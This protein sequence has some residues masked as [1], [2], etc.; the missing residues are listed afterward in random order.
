MIEYAKIRSRQ[1]RDFPTD[2]I[3][4]Q[5]RGRPGEEGRELIHKWLAGLLAWLG[6]GPAITALAYEYGI[7]ITAGLGCSFAT[8]SVFTALRSIG[9][10]NLAMFL[11]LSGAAF[12]LVL[13]PFLIFGWGPFPK[14]GL[15]G[16][17]WAT[18]TSQAL[19]ILAGLGLLYT[20][21]LN[22]R[23]HL[24]GQHPVSWRGMLAMLKVGS[25]SW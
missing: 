6:G 8:Y 9:H 2:D 22:V 19:T 18:L 17:A 15:P 24:K 21:W 11:M 7:I 5:D 1:L 4:V 20:P 12:N 10:P 3:R 13:D 23:L 25:S 14:L 16:A